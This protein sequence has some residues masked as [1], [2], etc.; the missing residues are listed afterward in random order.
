M[1]FINYFVIPTIPRTTNQ[2][3]APRDREMIGGQ[4]TTCLQQT[5]KKL[6]P[7]THTSSG[8]EPAYINNP[9]T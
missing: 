6:E 3:L 5:S 7:Q 9:K 1:F 8:S 4:G 2:F